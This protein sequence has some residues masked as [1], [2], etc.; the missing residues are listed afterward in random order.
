MSYHRGDSWF[1]INNI[2]AIVMHQVDKEFFSKYINKI[3]EASTWELLYMGITGYAGELSSAKELRSEGCS[4]QL[5][6][7]S[8]YIEL[9]NELM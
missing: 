6:S 8:T 1:W 4:A 5:W 2:T 3:L 7:N 9:I